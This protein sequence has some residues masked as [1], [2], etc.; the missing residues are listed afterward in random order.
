[1]SGA[2]ESTG[3]DR[4]ATALKGMGLVVRYSVFAA[5]ATA[6]N[7]GVQW[8][9]LAAGAPLWGAI[10]AGTAVGLVTKFQLDS[11]LIFKQS[12]CT[13]GNV[14]YRFILYAGT[15][16]LTTGMFWG[17]ELVGYACSGTALGRN[18][19][20]VVGLAVGYWLK[21]RMDERLVFAA[22]RP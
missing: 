13:S 16:M 12:A 14:A 3:A 7:L 2:M 22:E 15:G 17:A 1:M 5:V 11:R 20:A 21:F 4:S 10:G 6:G 19:G 8:A 9:V 18:L